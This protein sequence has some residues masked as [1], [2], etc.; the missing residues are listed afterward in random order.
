MPNKT[1]FKYFKCVLSALVIALA[2][3]CGSVKPPVEKLAVA[4][5]MLK[6]AGAN[7]AG[8]YAPLEFRLASE[9]LEEAR[10]AME[11]EDYI[12]AERL[13]DRSAM[14]ARTA[15]AKADSIR[16]QQTV[17]ELKNSIELLRQELKSGTNP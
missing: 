1:D 15:L 4:D 3:G 5:Q 13:A 10:Q 8:H 6:Q 12:I 7:E 9:K 14:D 17:N 11:R 16:A 2:G